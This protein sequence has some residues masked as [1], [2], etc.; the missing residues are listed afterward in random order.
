[1]I[2]LFTAIELPADLRNRLGLLCGGVPGARW[3]TPDRM[4]L[5]L[6]FIGEVEEPVFDDIRLAL[7]GVG[8]QA[9][10][11]TVRGVSTFGDRKPRVI[12]AGIERSELLAR[13]KQKIDAV[14]MKIGIG[15]E[16]ER[17][18]SP[19]ITLARI[20]STAHHARIGSFLSNNSLFS[21]EPFR[22]EEFHLYS[23]VL[24][25]EGSIYAIEE[26]YPLEELT[27]DEAVFRESRAIPRA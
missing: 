10:S 17:K 1:M 7:S 20:G 26:T 5:T 2:R 11:L 14:L 15:P 12:Y 25:G 9:F 3:I 4:H 13:L 21:S 18:F 8:V 22:V 27:G 16:D 6:R 19:H 24:S 23:S